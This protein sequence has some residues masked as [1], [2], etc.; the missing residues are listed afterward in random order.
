MTPYSMVLKNRRILRLYPWTSL[1]FIKQADLT[2]IQEN[3]AWN[4]RFWTD[5]WQGSCKS[6]VLICVIN[7]PLYQEHK[8]KVFKESGK[9]KIDWSQFSIPHWRWFMLDFIFI[10]S[11]KQQFCCR[12]VYL[13]FPKW[14]HDIKV[15]IIDSCC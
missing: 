11:P 13:R 2:S 3:M 15:A 10:T 6:W 8:C 4:P 12:K 9:R 14:C 1:F 7:T 5:N